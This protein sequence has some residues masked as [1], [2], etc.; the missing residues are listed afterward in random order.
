MSEQDEE[1]TDAA[2][3]RATYNLTLAGGGLT[4]EREVD[5][6]TAL[7]II[8]AVM[9]GGTLPR[10]ASGGH[11]GARAADLS[12]PALQ[13]GSTGGLSAR[14]YIDEH[15]AKR[16]VDKILALATYVVDTRDVDTF[17]SDDVKRE[18][19]NAAE[20]VP[21]N[22]ARDFKWA[23]QNDWIAPAEGL[24]GEYYVTAKGRKAL[25]AKFSSDVKKSTAV[26]SGRRKRAAGSN[27]GATA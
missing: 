20:P 22:Y 6:A 9:G 1:A 14:G 13:H 21:G 3:T 5:E 12:R 24:P 16:N 19:R 27:A 8:A 25:E 11:G 10:V 15:D 2:P 18:F 4:I 17:T 26:K 23:V 7:Q